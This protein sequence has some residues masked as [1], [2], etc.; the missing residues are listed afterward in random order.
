VVVEFRVDSGEKVFPMVPAGMS[1][2][3]LVLP[4]TQQ[5]HA[6]ALK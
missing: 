1:N 2:D 6:G 5:S 4:P 3:E